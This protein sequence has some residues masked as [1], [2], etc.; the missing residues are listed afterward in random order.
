M[1]ISPHTHFAPLILSGLLLLTGA[2]TEPNG[3]TSDAG[4]NDKGLIVLESKYS[5]DS[6]F[7]R[8]ERAL[9]ENDQI[10]IVARLDHSANAD[11]VD[12]SLRPTRILMFGNPA[13]G[14]PLMQSSQTTGIDLPQKILVYE[15]ADGTVHLAYNNPQYLAERHD[16]TDRE[17]E[18]QTASKALRTLAR[19]AVGR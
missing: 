10:S 13:I 18:L 5:V 14:T 11:R 3:S 6:T 17:K 9:E 16:I 12:L 2:C 4:D 15:D 19:R 1:S 7:A 8:M